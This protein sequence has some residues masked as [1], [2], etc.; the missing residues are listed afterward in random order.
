MD[1]ALLCAFIGSHCLALMLIFDRLMMGDCY[2]NKSDH[3]WL[4]SSLAGSVFGLIATILT[5]IFFTIFLNINLGELII[6]VVDL[7]FPFGLLMIVTGVINIQ[8]MRHYF[9]LFIP[10][11]NEN[12]NETAIAMWLAA[13]PIFIFISLLS[14][15]LL[16]ID[17]GIFSELHNTNLTLF[18]G[19]T[20]FLAT[21]TMIAFEYVTSGL[22]AFRVSRIGEVFKMVSCIVIYTILSSFILQHQTGGIISILA[23]QPFYFLGFAAGLRGLVVTKVR[24]EFIHAWQNIKIYIIPIVVVEI[25]GMAV[26]YFEFFALSEIDPTLVNLIIGAHIIPVF[27]LSMGLSILRQKMMRDN[28]ERLWFLGLSFTRDTLPKDNLDTKKLLLFFCV[29]GALLLALTQV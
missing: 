3:A 9:R 13:V 6:K 5:W 17:K 20:I 11:K 10:D 15:K 25:I 18:F 23:L 2:K 28:T 7:F 1:I 26:Y 12:V 29:V 8:V 24:S 14:L 16:G 27:I 22:E 4:V 19:F 21:G